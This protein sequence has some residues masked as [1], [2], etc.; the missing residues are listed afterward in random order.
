MSKV[1]L[2]KD[3]PQEER[4][5]NDMV[6]RS[7]T[8]RK[9]LQNPKCLAAVRYP[10]WETDAQ[11]LENGHTLWSPCGVT[12]KPGESFCHHHGG[13]RGSVRIQAKLAKL[14]PFI[15]AEISKNWLD[16]REVVASGL[17]C[18][19]FERVINTN[20]A[21]GYRLQSFHLHQ[22]FVP[23]HGLNETIIAVFELERRS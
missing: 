3:V 5:T 17:I 14:Q 4:V 16:G 7:P 2:W 19:Q 23:P 9:R 18:Q 8:I 15:V 13:Q 20:L 11:R 6:G 1:R 22:L 12:P 10:S 21:R